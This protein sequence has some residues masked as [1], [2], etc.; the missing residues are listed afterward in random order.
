MSGSRFWLLVVSNVV[1]SLLS[2]SRD[3]SVLAKPREV[4]VPIGLT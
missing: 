1:E 4:S 2:W 3:L